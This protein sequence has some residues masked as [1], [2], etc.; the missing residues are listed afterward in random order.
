MSNEIKLTKLPLLAEEQMIVD[1]LT[2]LPAAV[3]ELVTE[4]SRFDWRRWY[5]YTVRQ[6]DHAGRRD[7]IEQL[8]RW[9]QL[10]K[11][12]GFRL[13]TRVGPN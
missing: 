10:V 1:E 7:A 2:K 13:V 11:M 9:P 12:V 8:S 6:L 5:S 3:A 4:Y